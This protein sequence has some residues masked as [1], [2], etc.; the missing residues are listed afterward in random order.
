[1]SL[2][3]MGKAVRGNSELAQ[4]IRHKYK[5][6]NT[7]GYSLNALVDYTDPIDILQHLMIGSEGTLGFISEIT[8]S[9]V[10]EHPHKASS[11]VFFPDVASACEAV[12]TLKQQP[13]DAVEM[14]DRAALRSVQDKPGVP[15]ELTTLPETAAA[16]L[17]ET[18]AADREGLSQQISSILQSLTSAN[19]LGESSFTDKPAEFDALWKIRKGLFPSVGAMRAAGTAVVIE[20]IAFPLEKLAAGTVELQQM[21]EQHG[22]NNAIIFGHALEGNLHFVITP[23]FG[24]PVEV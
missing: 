24:N 6:K 8:L 9:T 18:R 15:G 1:N 16:L 13:V 19:T 21:F 4:R 11:L 23:D 14:M 5:I 20:D 10:P 3:S 22:Y 2:E 12:V 7:T 17:I